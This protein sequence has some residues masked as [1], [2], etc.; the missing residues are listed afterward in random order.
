LRQHIAAALI[1]PSPLYSAR[2]PTDSNFSI[3]E[4]HFLGMLAF[5]I[6]DDKFEIWVERVDR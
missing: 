3:E 5:T 4:S 6:L 1:V 2:D